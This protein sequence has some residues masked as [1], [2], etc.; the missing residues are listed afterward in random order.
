MRA[1]DPI[2]HELYSC[3][4]FA[5]VSH[6]SV[7]GIER[8][9]PIK[10]YFFGPGGRFCSWRRWRRPFIQYT[11]KTVRMVRT[12]VTFKFQECQYWKCNSAY[13]N[14]VLVYSLLGSISRPFTSTFLPKSK[15]ERTEA[16]ASVTIEWARCRPAHILPERWWPRI[17]EEKWTNNG[18]FTS[19]R[20]QMQCPSDL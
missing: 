3:P 7:L 17:L 9:F 8:R 13:R 16:A 2:P 19:Y 1:E 6:S 18:K 4:H 5:K 10:G 15:V 20:T 11:T 14:A 12:K